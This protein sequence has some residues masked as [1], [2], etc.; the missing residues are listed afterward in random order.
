MK[1]QILVSSNQAAGIK[2]D[3]VV[4]V[5]KSKY[6]G[7]KLMYGVKSPRPGTGIV[8]FYTNELKEVK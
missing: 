2:K 3:S 1:V 8:W 6:S 4:Y 5:S 7:S